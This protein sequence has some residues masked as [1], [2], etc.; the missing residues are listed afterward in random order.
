MLNLTINDVDFSEYT[1]TKLLPLI[2]VVVIYCNFSYCERAIQMYLVHFARHFN[3]DLQEI[4]TE[5][6]IGTK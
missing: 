2:C 4:N 5:V 3:K 1:K 6:M